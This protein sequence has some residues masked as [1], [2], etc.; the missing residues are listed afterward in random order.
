MGRN[1]EIAVKTLDQGLRQDLET[2]RP[3][4]PIKNFWGVQIFKG[5]HNIL[6]FQS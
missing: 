3:K 1:F 4:L 5:D 2:G 6:R